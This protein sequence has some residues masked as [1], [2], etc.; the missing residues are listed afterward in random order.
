MLRQKL[1]LIHHASI[2]LVFG[3]VGASAIPR[4]SAVEKTTV[5]GPRCGSSQPLRFA[6]LEVLQ[7]WF[8]LGCHGC[9][10]LLTTFVGRTANHQSAGYGMEPQRWN[11]GVREV[12]SCSFNINY[13]SR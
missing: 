6:N 13:L 11:S 1:K 12:V 3:E 4:V 5:L 8:G 10:T 2:I 7:C 9:E